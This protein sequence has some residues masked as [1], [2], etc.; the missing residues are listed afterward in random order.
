MKPVIPLKPLIPFDDPGYRV[1]PVA[2]NG[3][4]TDLRFALK[5][6][7]WSLWGREGLRREEDLARTF[8]QAPAPGGLPVLVGSG[9]GVCLGLLLETQDGPVAVLDKEGAV[10]AVTGLKEKYAGNPR[11]FFVS[12]AEPE[13]AL[14]ALTRWQ[15]EQGGGVLRPLAIPLYFRL[16]PAYY[17]S[18][19]LRLA[20]A[21]N[22]DFWGRARYPKFKTHPARVLLLSR[23]YFLYREIEAAL[24][25]LGAE[26]RVLDIGQ[27]PTGREGFV[28]ELL[29][30]VVEFKPDFV[31]T[32]N[33]LGLDREGRLSTLLARL[34]LPLASWFVD[35]PRLI[36]HQYQDLAGP[37]TAIFTWDRDTVQP[38]REMGF[39]QVFHLPL[40]TDHTRFK[41]GVPLPAN[42]SARELTAPVAFV[43]NSMQAQVAERLKAGGF[44]GILAGSLG[45]VGRAFAGSGLA[46]VPG[47]LAR[48]FP[49]EHAAFLA[50][51][52][53]EQRLHYE[54]L[55][56]WEATRVYRA[57]CVA[58]ILP[59]G[60][61]VAG[62]QGWKNVLPPGGWRLHK[63][64]DYYA[65]LPAFYGMG[66]IQLNTTSRQMRGA[67][68][69][70]VF[71]VPAAGGFLITDRREAMAELFEPG[72][73]VV[74]YDNPAEIPGLV[75]RYLADAPGRAKISQAARKRILA[76]HTYEQRLT[77]LIGVMR[78]LYG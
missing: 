40:A 29:A 35:A 38:V 78:G 69:Q 68:N 58:R 13:A 3:V 56:T 20:E 4:L 37:W 41:P 26:I 23:P 74:C 27:G 14:A 42:L 43:G 72:R 45:A 55:I 30:L 57:D 77:A 28:E 36:L 9:L 48:D 8:T 10:L 34:E 12:E 50:L 21:Q 62:D 71:D 76:E 52:G 65:E 18:L 46:G 47:F 53:N 66:A 5:D 39:D 67:V 22:L 70:R 11:V 59:F 51:P 16:D 2:E 6:K 32:V 73:E 44:T 31:L 1:E 63:G 60:A 7:T 24:A 54:A 49:E 25:R 64:L 61:L 75:E 19:A 17:R 15:A 33:H